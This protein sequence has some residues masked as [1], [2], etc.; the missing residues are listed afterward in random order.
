M[1]GRS[2]LEEYDYIDDKENWQLML[3]VVGCRICTSIHEDLKVFIQLR[4]DM[5]QQPQISDN[6]V[7]IIDDQSY[8]RC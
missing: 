3:G 4:I 2:P 1:L 6:A 5:A 7:E 8:F